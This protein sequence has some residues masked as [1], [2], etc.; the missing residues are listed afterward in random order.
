MTSITRTQWAIGD[1]LITRVDELVLDGQGSWL[2]PAAT[3][4]VVAQHTWL[5]PSSV[6]EHGDLRLSVHSFVVDIAG[7]RIVVDTGVG[8]SKVR[9]NPAWNDL[10]T[11]YL[12][13]LRENGFDPATVDFVVTTHVHRDHVGWNTTLVGSD[14][15]PTFPSAR[16]LVARREWDHWASASL[17]A[18]QHRMFADSIDPIREAGQLRLLAD[19]ELDVVDGVRLVPTPGHTPGHVSVRI[20]SGGESALISGDFLHHAVQLARPEIGCAVDV[21]PVTAQR[22]RAKQLANLADT[23]TLLL[24]THFTTPTGGHVR[25]V[26]DGYV[27]VPSAT[28]VGDQEGEQ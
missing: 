24:G 13:R 22:T 9:D 23:G 12:D 19:D 27:L 20:T 18:D 4:D 7:T 15:A 25:R 8:N 17:N 14:W 11:A 10:D 16:Y 1:A 5:D 26:G 3:H 28:T 6:D 21:D 2:L